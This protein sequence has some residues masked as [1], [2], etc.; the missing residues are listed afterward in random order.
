MRKSTN[1]SGNFK[2]GFTLTYNR[3]QIELFAKDQ[4]EINSLTYQLK[5]Y[6][7][8]TN[9]EQIFNM[10][11]KLGAGSYAEVNI[12]FISKIILYRFTF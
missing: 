5:K 2:Y 6:V 8:Q 1:L 3:K 7:V 11:D 12:D 10:K 9:F 4:D